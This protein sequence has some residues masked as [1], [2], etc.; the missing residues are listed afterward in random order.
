[1][2]KKHTSGVD[3]AHELIAEL[4]RSPNMIPPYN[5]MLL[6]T[7]SDSVCELY[8]MNYE[9][10]R[11]LGESQLT[12][13]DQSVRAIVATRQHAINRILRCCRT[14]V[15]ER[16]NRLKTLR[17]QLGGILT[18]EIKQNLSQEELNWFNAYSKMI[19]KYQTSIG[20]NG[21]NLM[22]H[23]SPPKSINMTVRAVK[24]YG[25]FETSEGK[26]VVLKKNSI[27]SLPS[28]DVQLLIKRGT[29]VPA[30]SM[31]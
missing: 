16:K 6:K 23:T 14:Y 21:L 2:N 17:W 19:S 12:D 7:A 4:H 1:M 3:A 8:D 29:L 5:G 22:L 11:S 9:T 25:E 20:E 31:I 10:I 26:R 15:E 18:P 24:D 13:A 27:H 30:E 28:V